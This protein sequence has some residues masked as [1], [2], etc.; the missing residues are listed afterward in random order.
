MSVNMADIIECLSLMVLDYNSLSSCMQKWGPAGF[1]PGVGKLVVW[2]RKSTS[3]VQRWSP[4]G[5]C[6]EQVVKIMHK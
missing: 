6:R 1:Y 2:G 5:D 4:G 3:R